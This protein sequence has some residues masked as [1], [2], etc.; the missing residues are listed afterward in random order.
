MFSKGYLT[1]GR[2]GGA[3]IRIHWSTPIGMLVFTG[4]LRDPRFAPGAWLGY[5]LVVLIHELGH[6]IAVVRSGHR[7]VAVDAYA[8]GG[9]CHWRG[10]PSPM[11][12][13]LIAWGGVIAQAVLA[14]GT[15][16]ALM[17]VG[18]PTHVFTADLTHAFLEANLWLIVTNLVPVPPLDGAEAWRVVPILAS[19]WRRRREITAA[20]AR[21]EV[22]TKTALRSLDE[23][24]ELPPMPDE[25]KR[26]LDKVMS[27]GRA[28]YEAE[29][30]AK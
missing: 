25:V 27:E 10:H 11:A 2:F 9:L 1:I 24:E 20:R 17:F 23:V 30:K 26:V 28:Q 18:R 7:V 6:A 4:F 21:A 14:I 19:R 13:A 16:I 8:L 22:A 15:L 5:L 3:P 12:R 29:K